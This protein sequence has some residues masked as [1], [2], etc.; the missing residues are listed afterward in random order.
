MILHCHFSKTPKEIK[1]QRTP[2]TRSITICWQERPSQ[3]QKTSMDQP[4]TRTTPAPAAKKPLLTIL[5]WLFTL[6]EKQLRKGSNAC[7]N[8]P[9]LRSHRQTQ[10]N[11]TPLQFKSTF[12][13][14]QQFFYQ[15]LKRHCLMMPLTVACC[16]SH[17]LDFNGFGVLYELHQ[18]SIYIPRGLKTSRHPFSD[19]KHSLV[20]IGYHKHQ[21]VVVFKSFGI[22]WLIR[23]FGQIKP[24]FVL[25]AGRGSKFETKTLRVSPKHPQVLDPKITYIWEV[26]SPENAADF[27]LTHL[28][29]Q[30]YLTSHFSGQPMITTPSP[31]CLHHFPCSRTCDQ[32]LR[33]MECLRCK[34]N[35]HSG[36]DHRSAGS[37]K[38]RPMKIDH[39]HWIQA[40]FT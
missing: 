28:P 33:C 14:H 32:S 25:M 37:L 7:P 26:L 27:W 31:P 11:T 5:Y 22:F 9:D 20:E 10:S 24:I 18:K 35:P 23:S 40:D 34:V 38:F 13:T 4:S 8:H 12:S 19:L 15:R 21:P 17:S 39:V 30:D 2:F 29:V 16:R 1:M 3:A 6:P 36:Q